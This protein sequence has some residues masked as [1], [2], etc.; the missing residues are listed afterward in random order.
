MSMTRSRDR[1]YATREAA[2][3]RRTRSTGRGGPRFLLYSG[4]NQP[5]H[6]GTGTPTA[7]PAG[8]STGLGRSGPPTHPCLPTKPGANPLRR[9]QP[10]LR[11]GVLHPFNYTTRKYVPQAHNPPPNGGRSTAMSSASATTSP[12]SSWRS[13]MSSAICKTLASGRS[14]CGSKASAPTSWATR[15]RTGSRGA[16]WCSSSCHRKRRS[17]CPAPSI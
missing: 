17:C 6:G 11:A 12:C 16:A 5:S 13:P 4:V 14:K 3:T 7:D 15:P 10:R 1:A 9:A 2:S 8:G